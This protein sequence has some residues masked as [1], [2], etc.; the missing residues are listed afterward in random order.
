MSTRKA[1]RSTWST[2]K[3]SAM[4]RES[5]AGVRTPR[6]TRTSPVR[7]PLVRDSAIARATDSAH[8]EADPATMEPICCAERPR[9]D[10]AVRP[11]IA[12]A[13]D[14]EPSAML[15]LSAGRRRS[16]SPS[17]G[18]VERLVDERVGGRVLRPRD[19]AH[20]PAPELRKRVPGLRMQR[21]HVRVLDLVLAVDLLGDELGVVDDLDLVGAERAGAVEAQQEPAVLGD[22]VRHAAEQ[23]A[24]FVEDL[25]LRRRDDRRS[26]GGSRVAAGAAVHVD[27]ELHWRLTPCRSPGTRRGRA[28]AGGR[29]RCAARSS[30]SLLSPGAR[31]C[32]GR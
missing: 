10:G 5:W 1:L 9:M 21:L 28:G 2:P 13:V 11:G 25:A 30:R 20:A 4:T 24:R 18:G 17:A 23:L 31:T 19:A 16:D 32:A 27:D 29:G 6:S 3:R 14:G 26:G 12:G 15:L 22:V 7:R 8:A